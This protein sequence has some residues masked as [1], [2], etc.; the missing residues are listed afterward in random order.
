MGKEKIKVGDPAV[1]FELESFNQGTIKLE[2]FFGKQKVV[3]IFSRYFGCPICQL[4]LN[5]LL[6]YQSQIEAKGA[7]I[8]YITQSEEKVANEFISQKN[9]SFPVIYS[10]KDE[11][12]AK[13]GLGMMTPEAFT[14]VRGRLKEALSQDIQHGEFEGWEKQGPG[15]FVIDENGLIVHALKGWL[16]VNEILEVL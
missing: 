1:P 5:I 4:D 11:L 12:Y 13:Y 3:L 6:E 10:T 8:L 2:D 7:K 16:N 15:Q 9:I 14:K